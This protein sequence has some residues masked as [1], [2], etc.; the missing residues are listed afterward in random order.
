MSP[1]ASHRSCSAPARNKPSTS[2]AA[3][4]RGDGF[5]AKF[6]GGR[7]ACEGDFHGLSGEKAGFAL[8]QELAGKGLPVA[9][10][11]RLSGRIAGA[12]LGEATAGVA[13]FSC[14]CR[15]F[16]GT[17]ISESFGG[18]MIEPHLCENRYYENIT[19]LP[20]LQDS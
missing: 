14:I 4:R 3:A 8:E 20:R 17:G 6:Q 15:E 12:A 2:A 19:F 11:A 7:I 5:A 18:P 13:P 9:R 16:R 1:G 10:A